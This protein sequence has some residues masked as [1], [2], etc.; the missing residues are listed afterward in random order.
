MYVQAKTRLRFFE[1]TV[2]GPD[3]A[4]GLRRFPGGFSGSSM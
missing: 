4:A 1:K 2:N 3:E